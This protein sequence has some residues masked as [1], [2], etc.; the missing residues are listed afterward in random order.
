MNE[1]LSKLA[2]LLEP[3]QLVYNKIN[4]TNKYTNI[5]KLSKFIIN[6]ELIM[7]FSNVILDNFFKE[8][9]IEKIIIDGDYGF[10]FSFFYN[11]SFKNLDFIDKLSFIK[12][13]IN[14]DP[15]IFFQFKILEKNY[16]TI[17][18]L[19]Q[20]FSYNII[21][22]HE[23]EYTYVF[24]TQFPT[25]IILYQNILNIFYLLKHKQNSDYLFETIKISQFINNLLDKD[26]KIT[27][28]NLLDKLINKPIN[29]TIID[30]INTTIIDTINKPKL[31]S[32]ENSIE[33]K[34]LMRLKLEK[35]QE[36]CLNNNLLIVY[37]GKK[38]LKKDLCLDLL[39][40]NIKIDI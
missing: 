34:R 11:E 4:F 15:S 36:L 38:L 39:F 30:T 5:S 26:S 9:N 10:I 40:H 20:L 13:K 16:D 35:L 12:N 18:Y 8:N 3:K 33:F 24:N 31:C 28:I 37:N 32:I 17:Y 23:L 6:Y 27:P 19:S 29:T 7:N 25:T 22:I 1:E 2:Y 14:M 21:I